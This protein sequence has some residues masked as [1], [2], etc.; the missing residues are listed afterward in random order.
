LA[1]ST[2]SVAPN[3]RLRCTSSSTIASRVQ[4]GTSRTAQ[5]WARRYHQTVTIQ[6]KP[7]NGR[8]PDQGLAWAPG[9]LTGTPD[10]M[11]SLTVLRLFFIDHSGDG[12]EFSV[13]VGRVTDRLPAL[14]PG[15]YVATSTI[16][17]GVN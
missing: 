7:D 11:E 16:F 10:G 17:V 9:F 3:R 2:A 4:Y 14:F 5:E 12:A 1:S 15:H 13:V 8:W 6:G